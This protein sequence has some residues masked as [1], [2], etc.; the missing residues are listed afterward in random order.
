MVAHLADAPEVGECVASKWY[1][2]AMGRGVEAG[3]A[4]SLTPLR[5]EF[6]A[7]GSNLFE[8]MVEI[9]QSEAFLYRRASGDAAP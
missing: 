7:A 4:C 8:L 2:F 3:D 6:V 5:Q 9:T 1:Q